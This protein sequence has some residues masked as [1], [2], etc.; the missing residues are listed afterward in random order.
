[1]T[2]RSAPFT[3]SRP[4]AISSRGVISVDQLLSV[5]AERGDEIRVVTGHFPLCTTELLG[6]GFTTLTVLRHPLDRT[7][8]Y[9]RHHRRTTP[10][11]A[12]LTLEQIYDDG[13]RF[14]G[15]IQ[16]HMTKMLSL[17]PGEMNDGALT[18][19]SFHRRAPRPRQGAPCRRRGSR[20]PRGLRVLLP[21]ARGALRMV[22]G[23]LAGHEPRA[24]GELRPGF[25][26][27]ILEENAHDVELYE[28]ARRL[29]AE[30]EQ[31]RIEAGDVSTLEHGDRADS[32]GGRR[33]A[34]GGG[35]RAAG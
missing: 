34:G 7:V 22:H 1:M 17:D 29:V 4:T 8:S 28:F 10:E 16:N 33:P 25:R 5:W 12:D 35:G 27:R 14:N 24:Q 2:S 20:Y 3:R 18:R 30:R 21:R 15:L 9:L 13:F 19:V 11:D 31:V 6:G 26:D 32:R 23:R